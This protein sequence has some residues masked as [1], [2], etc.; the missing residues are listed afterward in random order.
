VSLIYLSV[1]WV[2]GIFLG[3][4]FSP[5]LALVLVGLIPLPL[6]FFFRQQLKTIV[7]TSLC[8]VTLV[9]GALC[10]QSSLP[11]IDENQL[12]FYNDRGTV[13]IKG[14][15]SDYPEVRDKTTHLRFTATEIKVDDGW[16]PVSGKALLF[17]PRYPAYEYGDVL[18]VSGELET[19][20]Q[21]DGFDY[22]DYL[23]HQEIFSTMLYPGIE[24]Q[25]RG[26]GSTLLTGIY[27]LRSR[28]SRTMAN[29]L[30]EPKAS[31]AQG[32]IL[33][34]RSNIPAAVKDSFVKSGTAHLLAISGLH[35]SI[36]AGILLSL[37]IW[38][39]GRRHHLY[40][41]LALSVIWLF[42]LLTGMHPP[43]VRSAIMASLF[44][45]AELLGRQRSAFTAL[46]F[47]AAIM[48]GLSPHILWDASFQLSFMAMTG[49][50]F[51]APPLMALG[52]RA[53][54]ATLGESRAAGIASIITDSFA[55]TL[56][57]IIAVWPLI[58]HYFGI[59]SLVSLPATLF[60]LPALPAVIVTGV[61]A[62]GLGL[63]ALPVGQ[64]VAWLAWLFLTYMLLVVNIFATLPLAYIE[65]GAVT[66]YLIGAY[67]LGLALAIYLYRR[68]QQ[69]GTL[70]ARTLSTARSGMDKASSLISVIPKKWII[71]PLVVVA[72]LV[73][74]TAATMP[75]DKL[76]IS[77][78]N[79]G[80]GD[81]ILVQ[82]PSHHDILID[83]GPSPQAIGLGLG[84]K[85]PFWDRTIDLVILTHPHADHLTGLVEVLER[86]RVKQVLMPDWDGAS[87]I[88]DE[89]LKSIEAKQVK[90]SFAQAGQRI[91]LGDGVV[92]EVLNP[93]TPYLSDTESDIDNNGVALKI[94]MAEVSFLLTA[95]IMGEAE[96]ELIARRANLNNTVLK[97][98]HCGSKTSTTP[99][100]LAMANPQVAVISVG[101]NTYGHPNPEVIARL[102]D[103]LGPAGIY[104]TD[105]QGTI[106]FITDGERLWVIAEKPK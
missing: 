50:I 73:A 68:R 72:I 88:Y 39:F 93:P 81:A 34:I 4:K 41:W 83:G 65:V 6:L 29:I 7:L 85:M 12:R 25:Q 10:F 66:P 33:G 13:E 90:P 76:H 78:L 44:L 92:I 9:G 87:S 62:G 67:Y 23:A 22:K 42:A 97:V 30:P 27:R 8:L 48:V 105:E 14:M 47:A 52:R 100:F 21:L 104:R 49:L 11:A 54:K 106:E 55:I 70:T 53:V 43:I 86:Y 38:L 69:V 24:I 17:V 1:A 94:S 31:L 63:I 82:T 61:L 18:R 37:G 80:Q 58:A 89:W 26:Q 95:D 91:D 71:P 102:E 79:V 56:S 99:I 15:I 2:V 103:S 74:T 36:V 59:V 35:L 77:F 51:L 64:V 5:P 19:P 57:A 101:D 98:A 3:S 60:A 16:Q 45:T 28:L 32:V 40:I 46:A 96:S 20:P 84:Q 75:D